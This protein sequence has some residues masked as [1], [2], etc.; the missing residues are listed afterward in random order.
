MTPRLLAIA[1]AA[2][3]ALAA[4]SL[5]IPHAPAYDAWAWLV[6]GRELADLRLDTSSGPSFKPLPVAV[7]AALSLGGGAAPALWLV[8]VRAA[9]LLSLVLAG[10]LA[11]RLAAGAERALR[12]VAAGFAALCLAVV[13]DEVTAWGRQAAIGMSEPLLVAL[14]LGAVL[15]A[16]D[17]RSRLALALAGLAALVR[18]EVWPFLALYG[19]WAWRAEP[20]LRPW[21]A[22]LA[23]AVPALWLAPDLLTAGGAPGGGERALRGDGSALAAIGEALWRAAA[24]PLAAAWALAVYA[25][26]AA[27]P[28]TRMGSGGKR[29]HAGRFPPHPRA[30]AEALAGAEVAPGAVLVLAAGA[31]GWIA[32][33]AAMAAVG[34]AGLPRFMA[35]AIAVVGVL[36]G[37]GLASLLARARAPVARAAIVLVVLVTL[38]QLP[39][40]ATNFYDGL[41]AAERAAGREA[42]LLDLTAEI[43]G[44]ALLRC[45][46]LATSNVLVR[47]ALAWQ[48]ERPLSQV[49]SFGAPPTRSGAFVI[50]SAASLGVPARLEAKAELLGE[51]GEWR[52]YSLRC[53]PSAA[54]SSSRSAGVSGARR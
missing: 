46:K 21:L 17:G 53:S 16:L 26:V 15:A 36:G 14:V 27:W 54:A 10:A 34:F 37:V 43:G 45:G 30:G 23:L 32:L 40:R 13:Y 42:R 35:P 5:A 19:V 44:D 41:A 3:L 31:L 9:W 52:V 1:A 50:G 20:R 22:A 25:V 48:L 38:F 28:A 11:Y 7:A 12:L 39:G 51:R 6:W 24:M 8:V 2:C 33:V 47:T 4:A 49:V 29:P 18:P